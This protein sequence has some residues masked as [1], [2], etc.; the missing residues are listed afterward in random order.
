MKLFDLDNDIQEQYDVSAEHPDIVEEMKKIMKKEHTIPQV[1][2][3]RIKAL[4][5]SS[6]AP[7]NQ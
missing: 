6:S 4:E 1:D 5:E 7:I 3:F 2:A